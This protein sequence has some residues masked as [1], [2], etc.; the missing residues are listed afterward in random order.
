M[1]FKDKESQKTS[2]SNKSFRFLDGYF[3]PFYCYTTGGMETSER[4]E[5]FEAEV[6]G[7]LHKHGT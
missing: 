6:I 2:V 3:G 7:Q 1:K 4:F 5:K